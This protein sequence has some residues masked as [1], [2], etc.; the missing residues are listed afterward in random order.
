MKLLFLILLFP[1]CTVVDF[2]NGRYFT[3]ANNTRVK[4]D[5]KNGKITHYEC[6]VN[7]HST[8]VRSYGSVIGTGL[9]G[10]AGLMATHGTSTLVH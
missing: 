4:I 3:G 5:A 6:E 2:N 10:A 9:T 7:N 8:V 1:A